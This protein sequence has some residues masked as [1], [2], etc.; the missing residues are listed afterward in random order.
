MCIRDRDSIGDGVFIYGGLFD[1]AAVLAY[2]APTHRHRAANRSRTGNRGTAP[3]SYTHLLLQR[4]YAAQRHFDDLL[5]LLS[6][7]LQ[8]MAAQT[9]QPGQTLNDTAQTP[10]LA[11]PLL[12][13][14]VLSLKR[15][16]N[17]EFTTNQPQNAAHE[18]LSLSLIHI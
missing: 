18:G 2:R 16:D 4:A 7:Y 5:S 8:S 15:V 13:S 1:L 3:V 12:D 6:D 17:Y 10:H 9:H 11:V 14:A